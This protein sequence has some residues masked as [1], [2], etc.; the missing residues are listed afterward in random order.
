MEAVVGPL[1]LLAAVELAAA[2]R[3]AA[4]ALHPGAVKDCL[5]ALVLAWECIVLVVHLEGAEV[6]L[7]HQDLA[8]W[9]LVLPWVWLGGC[10]DVAALRFRTFRCLS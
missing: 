7:L 6:L 4:P 2:P 9:V 8:V 1:A 10:L 5:A 3:V